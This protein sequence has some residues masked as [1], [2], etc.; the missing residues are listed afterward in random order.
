MAPFKATYADGKWTLDEDMVHHDR[1]FGRI[2]VPAG[3]ETDLDSVP[4]LPFAYWLTKNAS[5]E[6]AVLHDSLYKAGHIS[7][8]PLSR[9]DADAIFLR[10]MRRESVPW[11]QR[12]LVWLGVRLGGWVPW[13][14]HRDNDELFV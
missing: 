14:K 8:V 2:V 6:A 4:R 12:R 1:V 11:W 3:T 9:A 5:V 10:A 13:G 7:F